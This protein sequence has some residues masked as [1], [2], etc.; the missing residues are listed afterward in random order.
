MAANDLDFIS[1]SGIAKPRIKGLQVDV[2][3]QYD[4]AHAALHR[5]FLKGEN[6][7]APY[8]GLAMGRQ[9]GHTSQLTVTIRPANQARRGN[10]PSLIQNKHVAR[11]V[12]AFQA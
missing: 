11:L 10:R 6:E 9:H 7:C 12:I 4:A 5:D 3:V 2:W 1:Q 8:A